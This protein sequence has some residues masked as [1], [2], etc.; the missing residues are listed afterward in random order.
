MGIHKALALLVVAAAAA[1]D[2]DASVCA[3]AGAGPDP[4]EEAAADAGGGHTNALFSEPLKRSASPLG[5]IVASELDIDDA[6]I[7]SFWEKGYYAPATPLLKPAEVAKARAAFERAF[8]GH[9]RT[10]VRS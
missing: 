9:A 4:E 7:K 2:D 1:A 3:G 6:A 8:E 5:A 10:R